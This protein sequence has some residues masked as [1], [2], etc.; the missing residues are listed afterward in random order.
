MPYQ[1]TSIVARDGSNGGGAVQN[2]AAY[3]GG[4]LPAGTIAIAQVDPGTGAPSDPA[5]TSAQLM[6]PN[7][8][9]LGIAALTQLAKGLLKTLGDRGDL[10][11]VASIAG[12]LNKIAENTAPATPSGGSGS[13]SSA[14]IGEP[15]DL[16]ANLSTLNTTPAAPMGLVGMVKTIL[17]LISSIRA[18]IGTATDAA[19]ATGDGSIV[20]VIRQIRANTALGP[21]AIGT[22]TDVAA[23][24]EISSS[25]LLA[26]QKAILGERLL[27][28]RAVLRRQCHKPFQANGLPSATLPGQIISDGGAFA[29]GA[30][31]GFAVRLRSLQGISIP[32]VVNSTDYYGATVSTITPSTDLYMLL[33]STENDS[34]TV[35]IAL[36]PAVLNTIGYD[37]S[38]YRIV[39][40]A[41]LL[42]GS[43]NGAASASST[44]FGARAVNVGEDVFSEY[45]RLFPS[46]FAVLV[47]TMPDRY[48]A[49]NAIGY[50]VIATYSGA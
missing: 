38:P 13:F 42:P 47:S 32:G 36:T 49:P 20:S 6:G 40:P 33:I 43:N 41:V 24:S 44:S 21:A 22:P 10:A 28:S 16:P 34:P 35:G 19:V 31:T 45:G 25:T 23:V 4:E 8:S 46:G 1:P 29:G 30:T 14:G 11:T 48:E 9:V 26:I 50:N 27:A 15:G 5:V 17:P 7:Q 37:T 18:A 3:S 39:M 12:L 2:L